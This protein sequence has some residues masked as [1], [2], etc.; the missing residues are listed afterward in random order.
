MEKTRSA[1]VQMYF[2]DKSDFLHDL[3]YSN[4]PHTQQIG[5]VIETTKSINLLFNSLLK[6]DTNLESVFYDLIILNKKII[7]EGKHAALTIKNVTTHP[8][9]IHNFIAYVFDITLKTMLDNYSSNDYRLV[10]NKLEQAPINRLW[11]ILEFI[12]N[13]MPFSQAQKNGEPIDSDM[14]YLFATLYSFLLNIKKHAGIDDGVPNAHCDFIW[15]VSNLMV[16]ELEM[17]NTF[18]ITKSML[19]KYVPSTATDQL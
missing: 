2:H 12:K 14:N 9:F 18:N 11:G 3:I 8:R 7:L 10:S 6:Y 4:S 5:A 19:T 15:D 16:S 13:V 17:L 1:W